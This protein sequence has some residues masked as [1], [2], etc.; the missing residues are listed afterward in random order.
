MGA[1]VNLPTSR[2]SVTLRSADPEAHPEIDPNWYATDYDRQRFK[3]ALRRALEVMETDTAKSIVKGETPP[4]G[5]SSISST[6]TD[7]EIE[8]RIKAFAATIHH[9]AGTAAMGKVVD[10]S[11][12]VYGVENLRIVDASIFPAPVASFPQA[13]MYAVAELAA[14]MILKGE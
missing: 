8:E 12:K 11:L 4:P 1:L 5:W 2:G 6:S 10:S 9:P 3:A 14:D 7:E 13:T